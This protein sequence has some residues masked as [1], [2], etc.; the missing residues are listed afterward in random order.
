MTS[1]P[2]SNR[3]DM[4]FPALSP[5]KAWR[6]TRSKSSAVED[7]ESGEY[8]LEGL[9]VQLGHAMT[10]SAQ[11]DASWTPTIENLFGGLSDATVLRSE[12]RRLFAW[13][14]EKGVTAIITGERGEGQLT[15][16]GL[17]EYVSDCVVLLDNH[18]QNQITTRVL[19]VVKYGGSTHGTNEYPFLIDHKGI[20]CFPSPPPAS[21]TTTLPRPVATGV[22]GL[23]DMLGARGYYRGS[24]VL[25]SGT[26][27]SGKTIFG[28][29]FA[30]ATCSRGER[31]LYFAF[32]ESPGQIV[33]NVL[34]VA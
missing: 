16:H 32:E 3:W 11:N 28:S 15:R 10:R 14:K 17:E 21:G 7:E 1:P 9:F 20:A 8:D 18:V 6:S 27:G 4:I 23:D 24:S 5:R 2:M 29:H 22:Q 26:S 13:L 30:D 12:L 33:R 25:I 31:C 19:R 34:S